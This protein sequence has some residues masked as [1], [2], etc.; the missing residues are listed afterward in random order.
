[1][2]LVWYLYCSYVKYA[3]SPHGDA[4]NFIVSDADEILTVGG[5]LMTFILT[6]I[7][8]CI[9]MLKPPRILKSLINS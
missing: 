3:F 2:A 8:A 7:G 9:L 5:T 4:V 1:M 6:T